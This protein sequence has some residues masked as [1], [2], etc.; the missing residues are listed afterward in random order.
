MIEVILYNF[1][2]LTLVLLCTNHYQSWK[3]C[4]TRFRVIVECKAISNGQKKKSTHKYLFSLDQF[5]KYER[6]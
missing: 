3:F 4:V 1:T 5:M 2:S 6:H